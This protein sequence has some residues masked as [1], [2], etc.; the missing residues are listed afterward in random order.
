MKYVF[1]GK[2]DKYNGPWLKKA[3]VDYC[4]D[5]FKP[6][7]TVVDIGCGRADIKKFL[8]DKSVNYIGIDR[9]EYCNPDIVCSVGK[10]PLEDNVADIVMLLG[11]D[12]S[13]IEKA[14][15]EIKRILKKG[16][17]I[18]T[19]ASEYY[20]DTVGLK[21][22]LQGINYSVEKEIKFGCTLDND[23]YNF[24]YSIC[25]VVEGGGKE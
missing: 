11:F 16:G 21:R 1:L 15:Y 5:I 20:Y 24:V 6:G 7:A 18:V 3:F 12:P 17:I 19:L 23:I 8:A 10:I 25:R 2:V 4:G 9:D 22:I 13:G 14:S